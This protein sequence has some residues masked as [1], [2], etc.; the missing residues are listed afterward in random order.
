MKCHFRQKQSLQQP[1]YAKNAVYQKRRRNI[2]KKCWEHPILTKSNT[3]LKGWP[4]ANPLKNAFFAFLTNLEKFAT[5][6]E[7]FFIVLCKSV[8]KVVL[9]NCCNKSKWPFL[10]HRATHCNIR[11]FVACCNIGVCNSVCNTFCNTPKLLN[12]INLYTKKSP[13]CNF[14][15]KFSS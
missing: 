13:C 3:F 2:V 6:F 15:P 14:W 10:Q 7:N 11:N 12:I 1:F 5:F 8:S 9:Q 4:N